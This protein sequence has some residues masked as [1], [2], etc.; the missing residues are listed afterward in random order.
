MSF[1]ILKYQPISKV[2]SDYEKHSD[3]AAGK[4]ITYEDFQKLADME[5]DFKRHQKIIIII[6]FHYFLD[7]CVQIY[8]LVIPYKITSLVISIK[9]CVLG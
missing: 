2:W 4:K 3:I 6:I 1:T 5:I 7:G 8:E 9:S